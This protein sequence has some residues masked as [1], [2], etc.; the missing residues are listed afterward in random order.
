MKEMES[1]ILGGVLPDLKGGMEWQHISGVVVENRPKD[2]TIELVANV[3]KHPNADKLDLCQVLGFKC[4]TK[5]D[6]FKDGDKVIYV[7]PD[8][9]FPLADWAVE[10]RKYSPKRIKA[11]RLRGEFSEGVIIPFE[12]VP[13]DVRTVIANYEV[14]DS[15]SEILGITHYQEPEVQDNSAKGRLPNGIPKTDEER[16]ENMKYLPYGEVVDLQLKVDGQSCSYYYDHLTKKFGILGRNLE[17]KYKEIDENGVETIAN[18]KYV[19]NI[20]IYDIENKLTNFCEKEQVSMVIRGE[21]YGQGLQCHE[22]NPHAKMNKGWAM[23]SVFLTHEHIYAEKG[24]KY[25]FMNVAA[26]MGLPIAPMIQENV[27]LTPELV[28]HYSEDIN[29]L[30]GKPFEGIVV[31]TNDTTFKIINKYYD[32]IK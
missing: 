5:R 1:G 6:Q 20:A 26:E 23:F 11:I 8:T 32:S 16:F 12:A 13:E 24:H 2:A 3:H 25:Y 9:V 30:N 28:K 31:K 18:N 10:Y 19:E 14:G 4:V 21:S 27:V 7:R 17:M 22:H 15:V 29:E